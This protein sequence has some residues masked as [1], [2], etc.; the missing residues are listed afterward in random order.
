MSALSIAG[1][2]RMSAAA[3]SAIDDAT[4]RRYRDGLEAA[5]FMLDNADDTLG[6]TSAIREGGS[7]AGIPWGDEMGQ[8]VAW[9][10]ERLGISDGSSGSPK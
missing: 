6:I 3:T 7:Q 2:R 9:A 1:A 4:L 5:C 10:Y 8:F